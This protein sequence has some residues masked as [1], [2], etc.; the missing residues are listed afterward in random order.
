[1]AWRSSRTSR[2]SAAVPPI[3]A[4][5]VIIAA[6]CEPRAPRCSS[7]KHTARS[8]TS[9]EK[10]AADFHPLIAPYSQGSKPST[11]QERFRQ[12]ISC[13]WVQRS[14]QRPL[15]SLLDA[16]SF[17]VAKGSSPMEIS[18]VYGTIA[19]GPTRRSGRGFVPA[20]R[21]SSLVLASTGGND[22][23]AK[24]QGRRPGARMTGGR[25]RALGRDG[26]SPTWHHGCSRA[27]AAAAGE[28]P[29][30]PATECSVSHPLLA[31]CCVRRGEDRPPAG[32]ID[33]A[34]LDEDAGGDVPA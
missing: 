6:H 24:W 18:P 4:A 23:S 2:S 21:S 26:S 16:R 9:G 8:R 11:N 3:L 31:V 15:R 13:R 34:R 1:M 22:M 7:T 32:E 12:G 29:P 27:D 14:W 33:G 30:R 25:Q 20:K 5:I 10:L 17:R 28:W 19:E